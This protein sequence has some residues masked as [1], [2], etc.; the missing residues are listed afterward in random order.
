[1]PT[2]QSDKP[3][4]LAEGLCLRRATPADAEAIAELQAHAQSDIGWDTPDE[5][6]RLWVYDL[7]A[8]PH[9]TFHAEDFVVVEAPHTGAIVSSACLISQT[10]RY[11]TM[12]FKVGRLE[13]VATHPDYR[14]RGLVRAQF[15]L[16]HALSA[17]RGELVQVIT[18]IP[19]YYRQFGY[20][21]A[22]DLHG[23][24][25]GFEPHVPVLKEGES[26]P[27]QLRPATVEDIPFLM[28]VEANA[29]GR[30]LVGCLRDAALWRYELEG[31]SEG[32]T[33]HRLVRIIE[34]AAGEA[35]GYLVHPP[36]LWWDAIMATGYE[37]RAGV[38]WLAVTPSVVRYL[39]QYGEQ[40][41]SYFTSD[42]AARRVFGFE[43][44]QYH[45]V[46]EALG[47]RLPR[48]RP[49][50][51]WYMRVPDLPAFL[52]Q[53]APVLEARLAQSVAAGHTGVFTLGFYRSGLRLVF[54]QG[55]LM[56]IAP[57][58][59]EAQK[60]GHAAFPDLTFLQLLFGYRSLAELRYAF[61]DCIANPETTV[62]LNAL[63]PKQPSVVW[64]VS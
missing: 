58:Q 44:G 54:E 59:P 34:T 37:L 46:Y 3:R 5:R 52:R 45:P 16:L 40:A 8:R 22:L 33:E 61:A 20:E 49:P 35:V 36:M 18:G 39:W 50:Y 19:W 17:E 15:E 32:A 2:L 47:D 28:A 29:R 63:F 13:L 12:S 64:A 31:R 21:M 26:E 23:G 62:L 9:P 41:P 11:G 1:M 42:S 25:M 51:A 55:R 14:R 53:I 60:T 38:S 27:Y 6:L 30:T 7:V 43:L 57:W 24:R 56:E 4:L 10:W 48:Q